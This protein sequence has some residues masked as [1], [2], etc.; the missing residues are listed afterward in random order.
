VPFI[1][2]FEVRFGN[3][4]QV[5]LCARIEMLLIAVDIIFY[6]DNLEVVYFKRVF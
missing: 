2:E 6:K 3:I 1:K 5:I 4:F